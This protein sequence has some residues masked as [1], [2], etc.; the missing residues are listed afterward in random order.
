MEGQIA[1]AFADRDDP[2]PPF[3]G[4]QNATS[5]DLNP[6]QHGRSVSSVRHSMQDR[7][8]TKYAPYY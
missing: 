2:T 8:L 1:D 6:S 4:R 3:Q 5:D 7:L